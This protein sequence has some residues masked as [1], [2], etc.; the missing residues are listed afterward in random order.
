ME[1]PAFTIHPK[2]THLC[3]F[4]GFDPQFNTYKTSP[5]LF[6]LPLP[7]QLHLS[8]TLLSPIVVMEEAV[9][10][11]HKSKDKEPVLPSI[12]QIPPLKPISQ[13]RSLNRPNP[14]GL[15]Y[16]FSPT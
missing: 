12:K 6:L 13:V 3:F 11:A 10:P 5:F 14:Q 8:S 4:S 9:V 2:V 15:P 1:R 7:L 16:T